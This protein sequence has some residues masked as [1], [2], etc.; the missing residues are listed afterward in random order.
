MG[1]LFAAWQRLRSSNRS[2]SAQQ[3][4]RMSGMRMYKK[5][6][7]CHAEAGQQGKSELRSTGC[8]SREGCCEAAILS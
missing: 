7:H 1:G 2:R 5:S 3:Q 8:I 4:Q 6:C